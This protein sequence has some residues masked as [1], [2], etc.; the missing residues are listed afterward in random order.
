MSVAINIPQKKQDTSMGRRLFSMA[1]PIVGGALGGPA[2]AAAGSM[3]ASKMSGGSTEDA[4]MSGIQGAASQGL[5]PAAAK[6]GVS[7]ENL[8]ASQGLQMPNMGDSAFGRRLSVIGNSNPQVALQ[9]GLNT[10]SA[11]PTDHPIRQQYTA[12]LVK[13]SYMAGR[14]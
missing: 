9:E 7:V 12:P 6:P 13:A 11:L 4:V 2:G 8:N 5:S 10:L 3:L 14:K 1:A